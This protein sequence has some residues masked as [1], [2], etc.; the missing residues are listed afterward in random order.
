[1]LEMAT[2]GSVSTDCDLLTA[3][4]N[5]VSDDWFRARHDG[6]SEEEIDGC[7]LVTYDRRHTEAYV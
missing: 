7:I 2:S 1:M 5:A 4:I 3:I 6:H